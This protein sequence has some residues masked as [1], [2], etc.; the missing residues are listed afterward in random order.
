M[1][2]ISEESAQKYY[3]FLLDC[4]NMDSKLETKVPYLKNKLENEILA[5]ITHLKHFYGD[6]GQMKWLF[7]NQISG[8]QRMSG[9]IPEDIV[10]GIIYIFKKRNIAE[11]GKETA[12]AEYLFIFYHIAKTINL[13]SGIS[14]PN[15]INNIC[16]PHEYEEIISQIEKEENNDDKNNKLS[17]LQSLQLE[18][19]KYLEKYFCQK[20][21][22]L[23]IGAPRPRNFNYIS[24]GKTNFCICLTIVNSKN[25]LGCEL[26]IKGN[27][28]KKA[29]SKLIKEKEI[30]ENK[31]NGIK[32]EWNELPEKKAVRIIMYHNG[33]INNKKEWDNISEWFRK[34]TK[35][36]NEV[37]SERIKK[38]II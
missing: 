4:H 17:E 36:L 13:F 3:K 6:N 22:K 18:Y 21:M 16:N 33:N 5:E 38:I 26:Y 15:K 27:N 30:I 19:W 31:L 12:Y 1:T 2:Y 9:F 7:N 24:I 20:N 28:A 29:Y 23:K 10:S 37:F 11:H 25:Q 32:L 34:N 35:L 14:I 8:Y